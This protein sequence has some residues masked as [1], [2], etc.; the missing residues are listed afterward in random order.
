MKKATLILSFVMALC[1]MVFVGCQGL[2]L[3]HVDSDKDGKCDNCGQEIITYSIEITTADATVYE[4]K[5]LTLKTSKSPADATVVWTIADQTVAT[6]AQDGTVTGVKAGETTA[7]ATIKE[8]V[9]ATV[10]VKVKAPEITIEALA[11]DT[12]YETQ[13]IQLVANVLPEGTAYTWESSNE[14]VATVS[15]TGLVTA[16]SAGKA[17]LTAK[18]S[19]TLT[20][21]VTVKVVAPVVNANVNADKF[22]F[23]GIYQKDAVVKSNGGQNSYALFNVAAG[24]YYVATAT[25]KVLA[26]DAN[27][28]WSRV[29]ISHF[30]GNN[31]YYGLQLSPG[32]NY[33][34][35]K[36]VTMVITDG[37]VGWG[38]VTDRSQVW[39]QHQLG[40]INFDEVKL[41]AVRQGN[42]YYAY[43]N[44]LLYYYDEGMEGFDDIDTVPA[45]NLGSCAAEFSAIS[46]SCGEDA[47]NAFL[48]TADKSAFYGS[49][50]NEKIEN[51]TIKFVN[52]NG[53]NPKDHAVKSIGAMAML[54][55]NV[56]GKVEFDLT[57]DGFGS[58]DA[59]PALAV[60]INRYEG[61]CWQ[62]RSLV[63]AQY[64]AGWTGWNSN[65]DL[66]A[67]IGDGGRE[68]NVNGETA[69]L[70]EGQTYH[71]TFTR[72][73][74]GDGQDTMLQI[75]DS[76]GNVMLKYAH[77][78]HD[79]FTGRV[80]VNF[81]CRDL[82]C[83]ITNLA[84][85][86]QQ[87]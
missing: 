60:T 9:S 52:A 38:S 43:I 42:K 36:I 30:N 37:N 7:T 71:V 61:E 11:T 4:G 83:T 26:P 44:D 40:A 87:A 31:A 6:I 68:Y 47:V 35:R 50:D 25:V 8:G 34:A 29:G 12:I 65:G 20:A 19:D 10:T 28:T 16:L 57:I 56:Q 78:W 49:Y 22:D 59:M 32:P 5:T 54:G 81:L 62:A 66:N 75:K 69:R 21:S 27:D 51:G 85:S 72:L 58:T 33:G 63:I 82:N 55:A 73:M 17:T 67:G 74:Y 80:V 48:A 77:G 24:K 41:T 18:V 23:S 39:N 13:T 76:D 86:S 3:N 1:L 2:C 15:E 45:M 53:T 79:G 14:D 70:E 84:I 46:A 64:K